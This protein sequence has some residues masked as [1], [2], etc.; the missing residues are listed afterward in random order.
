MEESYILITGGAGYIGSHVNRL[1]NSKG[2][3]TLVFDN[4][5]TGHRRFVQ[6]GQLVHGDLRDSAQVEELFNRYPIGSVMHFA[7]FAYVGESMASP[8]KYY[9]N[10]LLS[11]INLLDAMVRHGVDGLVFSSSCATYG[12]STEIPIKED[13][14]QQPLNPYGQSKLMDEVI[15]KDYCRAYGLNA[16]ALRYFNAAGAGIDA[17]IGEWHEP[18]PHLIPI[19]LDVA[20]GKRQYV[21]IY[22]DDYSSPDGTCIRDYIHVQDIA[23]AHLKALL[24]LDKVKGWEVFN[25]GNGNGYSVRQVI[26]AA[27]RVSGRAIASRVCERRPGDPVCLVGSS[28]KAREVL[29]WKPGF[30]EIDTIVE[31]AWRWQTRLNELLKKPL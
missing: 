18:E 30:A 16:V 5:V 29:G 8:A 1:L 20:L 12:Q 11:T 31:T 7:A 26:A 19:V 28:A 17:V 27:E 10:N 14:P 25:L 21:D 2:F 24:H 9:R 22:G 13:H 6:W 4:F 15:I 3:R 23:E